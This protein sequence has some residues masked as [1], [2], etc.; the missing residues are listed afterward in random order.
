[1]FQEIKKLNH[2]F[3]MQQKTIKIK[4]EDLKNSPRVKQQ[5]TKN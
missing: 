2:K 1:M 3:S 4:H 5:L